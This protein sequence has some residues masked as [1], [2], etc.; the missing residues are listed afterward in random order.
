MVGSET[1]IYPNDP[2]KAVK[3]IEATEILTDTRGVDFGPYMTQLAKTIRKSWIDL[4]PPTVFAPTVK[5]GSVA[6]KVVVQKDGKVDKIEVEESSG[7]V[8]LDGAA[9]G[10]I[11]VSSPLPPLP[12]EFPGENLGLRLHYYYNHTDNA[13]FYISPC[14]DVRVPVGSTLQFSVGG[15]EHAAVAW[16]ISGAGCDKG[17]CGTISEKG[18]YTAPGRVPDPPIVIVNATPQS[19]NLPPAKIQLSVVP[20]ASSQ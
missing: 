10:S 17:A 15:V 13:K 7:D 6:I 11:T 16:K 20:K 8:R 14:V 4:L 1:P 19:D 5:Q 9:L 12:K 2:C 18:L 3:P